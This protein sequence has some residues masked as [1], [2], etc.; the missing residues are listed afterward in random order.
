MYIISKNLSL[1]TG[2]VSQG[3][4]IPSTADPVIQFANTVA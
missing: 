3:P 4:S 2:W 1:A